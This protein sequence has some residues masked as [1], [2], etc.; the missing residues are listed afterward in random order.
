MK[1]LQLLILVTTILPLA[2]SIAVVV[3]DFSSTT[4]SGPLIHSTITGH[5]SSGIESAPGTL[6]DR[7]ELSID[8]LSPTKTG[9][10][11]T[12]EILDG[13]FRV[14]TSPGA[15][16]RAMLSHDSSL[17]GPFFDLSSSISD[18]VA[19][20]SFSLPPNQQVG[21]TLA[22]SSLQGRL[23]FQSIVPSLTD[24]YRVKLSDVEGIESF[25]AAF[26]YE[27]RWFFRLSEPGTNF[28]ITSIQIVPEPSTLSFIWLGILMVVIF[29]SLPII[30]KPKI[31]PYR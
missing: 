17:D 11:I 30:R 22:L 13:E 3:D 12:A 29:M 25:D 10:S 4:M 18:A 7:R 21:F 19:Q 16:G 26:I 24:V 6:F 14:A 31:N 15:T 28:T 20:I 2:S 8:L 9:E 27:T 5:A 23:L 1:I